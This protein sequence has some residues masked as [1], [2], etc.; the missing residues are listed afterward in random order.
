MGLPVNK[1]ITVQK[2]HLSGRTSVFL[3]K[4]PCCQNIQSFLMGFWQYLQLFSQSWGK[5]LLTILILQQVSHL[6]VLISDCK[7][8]GA[9]ATILL[10]TYLVERVP[11]P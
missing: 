7:P 4:F 1:Y 9:A 3:N 11:G 8:S 6:Q 5:L 10:H 2:L